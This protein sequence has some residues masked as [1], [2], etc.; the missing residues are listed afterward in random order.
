[1]KRVPL[2]RQLD[3]ND[4][5][6]TCLRMIA[7]YYGKKYSLDTIKQYCEMT[8]IGISMRDIVH[9][10]KKLGFEI[11]SVRVNLREARRMP[12]RSFCCVGWYRNK[13]E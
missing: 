8:R 3:S 1:M 7:A 11:A 2:Y 6:P 9:C 5:G 13:A 12:K 4:C 10:G